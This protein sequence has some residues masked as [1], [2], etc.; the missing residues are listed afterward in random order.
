[1]FGAETPNGG[2]SFWD[3]IISIRFSAAGYADAVLTV[4]YTQTVE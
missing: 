3:G 1:M 4:P 2:T